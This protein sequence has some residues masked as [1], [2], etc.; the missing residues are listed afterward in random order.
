M[1]TTVYTG[2]SVREMIDGQT[3]AKEIISRANDLAPILDR[4]EL[5]LLERFV[6]NPSAGDQ[7]LES[8]D[9]LDAPGES[10]IHQLRDWFLSS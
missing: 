10:E 3:L 5:N 9:M 7:I 2:P 1:A 4:S 6:D 8:E